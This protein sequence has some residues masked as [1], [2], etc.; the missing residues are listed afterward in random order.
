MSHPEQIEL[1]QWVDGELDAGTADRLRAHLAACPECAENAALLRRLRQAVDIEHEEAK[2]AIPAPQWESWSN[3]VGTRRVD[4]RRWLAMAASVVLAVAGGWWLLAPRRLEAASLLARAVAVEKAS[5]RRAQKLRIVSG[6]RSF[7]RPRTMTR[8]EGDAELRSLF[9]SASY[10]WDDPLSA[11]A[12]ADWRD[13]LPRKQDEAVLEAGNYRISTSALAGPLTQ[14]TLLL[15]AELQPIRCVLHFGPRTVELEEAPEV[16]LPPVAT[17]P[18]APQPPAVAPEAPIRA[19]AADELDLALALH[20]FHADLGD[21]VEWRRENDRILVTATG[22]PA[23]RV[24]ELRE[25]TA[26]IRSLEWRVDDAPAPAAAARAP[27]SPVR[28]APR[29]PGVLASEI[30]RR[31]GDSAGLIDDLL[32]TSDQAVARAHALRLLAARFDPARAAELDPAR[33]AQLDGL[34]RTH[35]SALAAAVR[36]LSAAIPGAGAAA[37]AP[38]IDALDAARRVDELLNTI[39]AMPDGDTAANAVELRAA[40]ARLSTAARALEAQ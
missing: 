1:I 11:S 2:D 34:R 16:L 4:A 20:R 27:R 8:E 14:A 23:A 33:R 40:L 26:H 32:A 29:I 36:R 24:R 38:A 28:A 15:T 7:V 31:G 3:L 6:G 10:R 18:S 22:L 5:P 35:A 12:F 37:P 13:Q 25:A 19:T 39:F 17:L 21:P 30:E 9:E